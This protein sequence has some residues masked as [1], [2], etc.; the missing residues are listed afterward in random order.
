MITSKTQLAEGISIGTFLGSKGNQATLETFEEAQIQT[1]HDNLKKQAYNLE[2]IKNETHFWDI[3]MVVSEGIYSPQLEEQHGG[4]NIDK[5]TGNVIVFKVI[6]SN[7]VVDIR[8]TFDV[9]NYL[10]KFGNYDSITLDYDTYK[11]DGSLD[12][13]II[14][15]AGIQ[16]GNVILT[17]LNGIHIS[18][19]TFLEIELTKATE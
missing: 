19:D 10:Q 9:A 6:N 1:I 4:L 14:I 2:L 5:E 18:P 3:R 7:G 17:A 15:Q 13:Q 11:A 8:R 12:V 16:R